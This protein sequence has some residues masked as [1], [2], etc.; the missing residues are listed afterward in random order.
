MPHG[1]TILVI[2]D[3][4]LLQ[5]IWTTQ[6]RDPYAGRLISSI[7]MQRAAHKLLGMQQGLLVVHGKLFG[8]DV[9]EIKA[10]IMQEPHDLRWWGM[11]VFIVHLPTSGDKILAQYGVRCKRDY[12]QSFAT[13]QQ[14][15][16]RHGQLYGLLQPMPITTLYWMWWAWISWWIWR[17]WEIIM[18]AWCL[19]TLSLNKPA[20]CPQNYL[21]QPTKLPNCSSSM[22]LHIIERLLL[23]CLIGTLV[24]WADF[25]NN[26][27]IC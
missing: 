3:D 7:E 23:S 8:H 26:S 11:L 10:L 20:W 21:T 27:S 18:Q 6:K 25:G 15:K 1:C 17:F 24:L 9:R 4:S 5:G 12:I 16:A 22:Y 19:S 14:V 2:S 13:C